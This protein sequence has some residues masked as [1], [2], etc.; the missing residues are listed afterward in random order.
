MKNQY[1]AEFKTHAL[2]K[3]LSREPERTINAVAEELNMNHHTLKRWMKNKEQQSRVTTPA[4]EKRPQDWRPEEKLLALH[5]TH[6]MN[7]DERNAWCRQNGIFAHHLT[8]WNTDF[9]TDKTGV[10]DVASKN[11]LRQLKDKN[12]QLERALTRKEK[13][14]AE[15]AA[16]LILQKKFN[17]LWEGEEK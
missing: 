15:A 6:S 3:V 4:P 14:L 10:S 8:A 9:C 16:L 13:A 1:S 7:N 11:E 5:V 2:I 12:V 17:A